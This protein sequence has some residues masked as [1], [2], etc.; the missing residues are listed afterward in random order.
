MGEDCFCHIRTSEAV[1]SHVSLKK[2]PEMPPFSIQEE[3]QNLGEGIGSISFRK[4]PS[5]QWRLRDIHRTFEHLQCHPT[6]GAHTKRGQ[7]TVRIKIKNQV[8]MMDCWPM[9]WKQHVAETGPCQK[10]FAREACEQSVPHAFSCG[11]FRDAL[12]GI[13][14]K[15]NDSEKVECRDQYSVLPTTSEQAPARAIQSGLHMV[16]GFNRNN[17]VAAIT[18]ACELLGKSITPGDEFHHL[19][20]TWFFLL[21]K[22]RRYLI[23]W[24]GLQHFI[25]IHP[26]QSWDTCEHGC[27]Q[28][29]PMLRFMMFFQVRCAE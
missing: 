17:L 26:P 10:P 7:D 20:G 22:A 15:R 27:R 11:G 19:C 18:S 14:Y 9:N 28:P 23:K 3:N 13:E 2:G 4:E 12:T 29:L 24:L 5:A 8:E 16:Q 21:H 6:V 1:N 25:C